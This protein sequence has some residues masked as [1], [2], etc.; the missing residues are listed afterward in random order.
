MTQLFA[1]STELVRL[2]VSKQA[3]SSLLQL[4]TALIKRDPKGKYIHEIMTYYTG[5]NEYKV[6]SERDRETEIFRK[7]SWT[8]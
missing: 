3:M 7:S 1:F 2:N 6:S 4:I 5:S 8:L